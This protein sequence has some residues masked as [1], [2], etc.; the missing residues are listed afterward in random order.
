[1]GAASGSHRIVVCLLGAA[2]AWLAQLA[3]VAA[4]PTTDPLNPSIVPTGGDLAPHD[5][6]DLQHQMQLL[7]GFGSAGGGW[8]ILPRITVEEILNDNVLQAHSPRRW[9]L[10]TEVAPGIAVAG[11]TARIRLRLNYQ[12]MLQMYTRTGSQNALTH[13]L[14]ATGTV[15]VVPDL[16]FVD[17]RGLAGVQAANGGIGGL[18]TTGQ[19]GLSPV[20]TGGLGQTTQPGLTKQNLVQTS[21][22][23]ISPY[24]LYR[25]GDI[26]TGKIGISA[27]ET[28]FSRI[29]GFT[30]VP[31]PTGG[32]S[33]QE[34]TIEE[35]ASFQTGNVLSRIRDSVSID[36]EQS[37]FSGVS[38]GN[39][40]RNSFQNRVDYALDPSV[41]VYGKLGWETI[42]YSGSSRFNLDGP[43]WGFGTTLTPNAD[44]QVTLGYGRENGTTAFTFDG[45]YAITARTR[46]TGSYRSGITTQTGSIRNQLNNA[47][48]DNN[49]NLVNSR[50]G[51]PLFASNNALG[52]SPGIYRFSTLSLGA[53]TVLARDTIALTLAHTRQTPVGSGTAGPSSDVN[54]GGVS[55]TH[56]VNP[57]LMLT[58]DLY[59]SAGTPG[60]G[61]SQTSIVAAL[62]AQYTLSET[63]SA[64]ARYAY[65]QRH[66]GTAALSMFQDLLIV[67]VTKQ[68]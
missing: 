35:T 42:D 14:A 27:S 54:T 24:M 13:Q 10:I 4:F 48:V 31:W 65:Y 22:F 28:A 61:A 17:V 62:S 53:T 26:G 47:T 21:S 60:A 41:S 16:L 7:S 34:S 1:M 37:R 19:A 40:R 63:V 51:A 15:T 2:A 30:S 12:P 43:I 68:F 18:G 20:T 25:F 3:P 33:Q 66:S 50:T 44:T 32:N 23:A 49:G 5:V 55:W 11:D 56:Q 8:T 9:D 52:V 6:Q 29:S 57:D 59:Y 67:G 36:S 38:S 39:S 45:R 64:F 46:L 58:A